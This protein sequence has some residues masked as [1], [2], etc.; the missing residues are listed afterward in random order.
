MTSKQ[1]IDQ[2]N[3][4]IYC[5][6]VKLK[7]T[8]SLAQISCND[9]WKSWI[10]F[11]CYF[12]QL[13]NN[14]NFQFHNVVTALNVCWNNHINTKKVRVYTFLLMNTT[15]RCQKPDHVVIEHN[16]GVVLN[17]ST[18]PLLN[19]EDRK[20][21]FKGF[22]KIFSLQTSLHRSSLH[23]IP[24]GEKQQLQ[25][26]HAKLVTDWSGISGQQFLF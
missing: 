23:R 1:T 19:S 2:S 5:Y 12:P 15:D 13:S 26:L 21:Y 20:N 25:I 9:V 7:G 18:D 16:S 3:Q 11:S 4:S 22:F 6:G 14:S 17:L 24:A 10:F 8:T